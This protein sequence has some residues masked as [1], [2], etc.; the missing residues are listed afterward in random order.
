[1][2]LT[3]PTSPATPRAPPRRPDLVVTARWTATLLSASPWGPGISAVD[4]G[5]AVADCG[6]GFCAGSH[7]AANGVDVVA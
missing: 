5:T 6:F 2:P 1:V 7:S 4:F 3:D